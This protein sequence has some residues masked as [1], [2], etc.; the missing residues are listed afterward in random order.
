MKAT[1]AIMALVLLS[2][3]AVNL[4]AALLPTAGTTD[5][6][7]VQGF[8]Y[9]V[10]DR[11]DKVQDAGFKYVR[12]GVPW[13]FVEKSPGAYTFNDPSCN[14]DS[15]VDGFAARGIRVMYTLTGW[16]APSG[17]GTNPSAPAFQQGFRNFCAA[18]AA[19]YKNKGVMFELWNEP[20]VSGTFWPWGSPNAD[21]YMALIN[22][23]VPAMRSPTTGDPNCTIIG[24]ATC[25]SYTNVDTSYLTKCFNYGTRYPG[26]KGL[27]D[28]VDAVSVHPYQS[29]NGDYAQHPGPPENV[30]A[31][32]YTPLTTLMK[33][34]H[35]NVGLPIVSSEWGYSTTMPGITAQIQ[36]DYLARMF[37]VNM[38]QGI[39]NNNSPVV[40]SNW[41]DFSDDGTNPT[42][43]E[44]HFGTMTYDFV[45]KPAYNEMQLLT[46]SLAGETL[47]SKLNDGYS[48]DWL[49]VFTGGGHTTLAA[50]TTGSA[51]TAAVSGWG[52]LSLSSTPFYV[53][54]VPEPSAFVLLYSGLLGVLG[55]AW[56][57]K[58]WRRRT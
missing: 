55:Y 11:M 33:Q 50:W 12:I 53:N 37:L 25:P 29:T 2:L 38:S 31:N 52:T 41:Y 44:D 6:L 27:L 13:G 35:S 51:H 1:K 28:L 23:A 10:T 19:H 30:V 42:N 22:Q 7:S 40:V 8:A 56:M 39:C 24:P 49:L 45:P 5:G 17:Y 57:A 48:S 32:T 15:A 36:G 14:F 4:G 26:Q 47:T 34:Y 21:Q 43:M 16:D 46:S 18:A 58:G 54:Q 9:T 20:N 3:S